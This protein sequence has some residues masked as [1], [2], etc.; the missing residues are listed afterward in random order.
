MQGKNGFTLIELTLA[1]VITAILA[2]VIGSALS[3]G[4]RAYLKTDNRN[5][6]LEEA[7]T[8]IERLSKEIRNGTQIATATSTVLCFAD[9][10]GNT[11]SFRY[12]GGNNI[13]L[14]EAIATGIG[15][16]PGTGGNTLAANITSFSFSYIQ[17]SGASD[18]SPPSNTKRIR[19]SL[20]ATVSDESVE[21]Q[22]EIHPRGL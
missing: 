7:R 9:A 4:V 19:V 5:E 10:D 21:L 15:G 16:C 18:P 13:I 12:E 2:V 17:N 6:A 14:R 3:E 22:T 8:A 1:I 20:T 11:V